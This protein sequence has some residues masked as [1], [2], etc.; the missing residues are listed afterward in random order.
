MARVVVWLY[1]ARTLLSF[2]SFSL[3]WADLEPQVPLERASGF[4]PYRRSCP[5]MSSVN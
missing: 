5:M 2:N 1:C 3:L 4:V